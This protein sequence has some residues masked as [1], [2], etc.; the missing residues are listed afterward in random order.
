MTQFIGCLVRIQSSV[1]R[2]IQFESKLKSISEN[3][4]AEAKKNGE[5]DRK[6]K[7]SLCNFLTI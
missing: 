3:Q 4:S 2:R 6:P 1:V 7:V 5:N